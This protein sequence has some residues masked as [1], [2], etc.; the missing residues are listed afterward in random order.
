VKKTVLFVN[1][2]SDISGAEMSLLVLLKGLDKSQYKPILV[3]PSEGMLAEKVRALGIEVKIVSMYPMMIEKNLTESIKDS[4]LSLGEMRRTYYLLKELDADLVHTNSYRIGIPFSWAARRINIPSIWHLRD[5]PQSL[6]KKK[7]VSG[8]LRFPD[9]V[10]AISRAVADALGI[11]N[12]Q[13]TVVIYNGVDFDL[14]DNI[15]PGKFRQELGLDNDAILFCSIGQLIP[16]KG[17]DLLIKAFAKLAANPCLY[18]IIV[19]GNVSP[20]WSEPDNYQSHSHYLSEM[21]KEYGLGKRVIFTGFRNDIPQILTDVDFYVHA[22]I[23]PEPFG[24]VLVEAMAARK[25]V[26]AP[27]WGGIPE[28]VVNNVTGLLFEPRN[29]EHLSKC[30]VYAVENRQVLQDMGEAGFKVAQEK[31]AA[32]RYVDQVSQIYAHLLEHSA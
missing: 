14:F 18:L 25:P 23:A 13:K 31:F 16:W 6:L 22:A 24:R 21:V 27:N 20:I 17:H 32:S 5:I 19:G 12:N 4:L 1:P 9:K 7:L 11:E 30:L 10:I 26:I 29:E 28:I 15:K 2:C 8:L 3:I